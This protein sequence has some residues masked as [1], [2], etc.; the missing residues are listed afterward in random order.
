[1]SHASTGVPP[2]PVV[3]AS[4]K[5]SGKVP[6]RGVVSGTYFHDKPER[7]ARYRIYEI[8]GGQ[9]LGEQV[10]VWNREHGRFEA[11]VGTSEQSKIA[12]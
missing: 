1:V 5:P 10:R 7:T 4:E 9:I 3:T 6:V 8:E 2:W 11:D 12:T